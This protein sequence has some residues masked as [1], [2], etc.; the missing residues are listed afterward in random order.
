[1]KAEKNLLQDVIG[2]DQHQNESKLKK[3]ARNV[4]AVV[5]LLAFLGVII[6]A[7]IRKFGS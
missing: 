3:Y 7:A 2:R 6:A 5:A 1:M 4:F